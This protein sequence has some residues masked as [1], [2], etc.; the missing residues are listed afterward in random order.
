MSFELRR[1]VSV[2]IT[3]QQ[4]TLKLRL[5]PQE[6]LHYLTIS[7]AQGF[8]TVFAGWHRVKILY[9]VVVRWWLEFK[10]CRYVEHF[11]ILGSPWA[12]SLGLPV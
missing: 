2:T 9:A 12:S 7:M 4:V 1:C 6:L 8:R 5:R 10:Q 11:F 3:V